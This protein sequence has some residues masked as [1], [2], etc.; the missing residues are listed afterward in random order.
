MYNSDDMRSCFG[1]LVPSIIPTV[2]IIPLIIAI[3]DI[4]G[5]AT[6]ISTAL[7]TMIV[8]INITMSTVVTIMIIITTT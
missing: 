2:T 8:I 5:T 7:A 1:I 3:N 6:I 4:Y